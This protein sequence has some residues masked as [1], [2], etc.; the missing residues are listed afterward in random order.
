[1]QQQ[2]KQQFMP[3]QAGVIQ[4]RGIEDEAPESK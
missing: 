3:G 2:M 1:M 4:R